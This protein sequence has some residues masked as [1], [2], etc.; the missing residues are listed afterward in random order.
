M[1]VLKKR[2]K[3]KTPG[4][5]L[6]LHP[7]VSS[8]LL[9]LLLTLVGALLGGQ[10]LLHGWLS[11]GATPYL[12]AAI[13]F[14]SVGLGSLP[15]SKQGKLPA[16]YLNAAALLIL[17]LICKLAIW[18]KL[19]FANWTVPLAAVLGATCAGLLSARKKRVRH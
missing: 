13:V 2:S 19:P 15:A 16:A 5:K 6:K 11:E 14:L 10:V 7:S 9:T 18:P 4:I 8:V 1:G 17:A 12:A 3:R